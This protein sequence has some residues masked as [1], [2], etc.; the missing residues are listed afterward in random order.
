MNKTFIIALAATA[1]ALGSTSAIAAPKH[2]HHAAQKAAA[3]KKA[4]K[5]PIAKKKLARIHQH[6][7]SFTPNLA[8]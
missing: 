1:F 8:P 2:K 5:K 6:H 3:K 7:H 4:P